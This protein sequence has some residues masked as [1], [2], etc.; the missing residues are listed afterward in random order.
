MNNDIRVSISEAARLFGVSTKTIRQAIKNDEIIYIIVNGR[1]KLNFRS[2][3]TWSQASTR[4]RN[5]LSKLGFGQYVD[6]WKI[7]NLKYSPRPPQDSANNKKTDVGQ[8]PDISYEEIFTEND[9]D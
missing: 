2:L 9:D 1:Y 7:S 8:T 4:R 6:K 5:L 3:I